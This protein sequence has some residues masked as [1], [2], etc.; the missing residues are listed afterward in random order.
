MNIQHST[1]FKLRIT[2]VENIDPIEVYLEDLEPHK[3]QITL[4]CWGNSWTAFWGGM[5]S[6][7]ITEFF[8][9]CNL[10]YLVG[11]L[12][13]HMDKYEPD[14]HTFGSEMR[15]KVCEMRRDEVLSKELAR[16][17]Y[18]VSDWSSYVTSNPYEPIKNPCFI[19]RDEFEELDFEGF[20]VPERLTNEY[21][22]LSKII[23]TV[24]TA[25]CKQLDQQGESNDS[26][27]T[28]YSC[29]SAPTKPSMV[30][31]EQ[32]EEIKANE[33]VLCAIIIKRITI[34]WDVE[35]SIRSIERRIQTAIKVRDFA[36]AT[37]LNN[38]SIAIKKVH[39]HC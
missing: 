9:D 28:S 3:G 10:G 18:D 25:I 27:Q 34:P 33:R 19:Y 15:Q 1:V 17:L 16:E 13:P 35:R 8:R 23:E 7:L 26:L 21:R 38:V 6:R 14:F 11:C 31:N 22:Y 20:D 2:E 36:K 29:L 24:Q 39:N 12:A 4:N 32:A 37:R 5:G 30:P